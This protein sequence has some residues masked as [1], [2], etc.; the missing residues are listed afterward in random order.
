MATLNLVP[1]FTTEGSVETAQKEVKETEEKETPAEPPADTSEEVQKPDEVEKPVQDTN[2][3]R[4]TLG[5]QSEIQKLKNEI[6]ELRG[7]KRELK[8]DELFKAEQKLDELK[9]VNPEDASLVER[10][11]R[12]KG[13]VRKDEVDEMYYKAVQDEELAKFLEKYP[14]YKPQND[15]NDTNWGA[16]Q[17]EL[18]FYKMP[19]NP[20]QIPEILERAHKATFKESDRS[21]P[22]KKRAVET[23]S[24]GAGGTQRSSSGKTLSPILRA[25]YEQGGWSEE[26]IKSIESRL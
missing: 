24:V 5:L 7:Q 9:D 11:L 10:I 26:E 16:L 22:A 14:E 19:K 12:S 4:A 3:E 23:A 17:R 8:K 1:E 15:P 18:G 2:L 6:V 13:Y 21:L 20:R 25:R